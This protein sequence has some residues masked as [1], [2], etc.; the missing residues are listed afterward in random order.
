MENNYFAWE[1]SA[2]GHEFFKPS[3]LII[4]F[5]FSFINDNIITIVSHSTYMYPWVKQELYKY[6][7]WLY[8]TSQFRHLTITCVWGVGNLT[9]SWLEWGTKSVQFNFDSLY[10]LVSDIWF[11]RCNLSYSDMEEFKGKLTFCKSEWL[12][13]NWQ[14]IQKLSKIF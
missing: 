3:L 4:H 14:R 12:I 1:Y 6:V 7:R 2:E 13:F 5:F 9:F 8:R 11:N 10:N